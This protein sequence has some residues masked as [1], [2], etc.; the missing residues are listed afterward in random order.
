MRH[1]KLTPI[2]LIALLLGGCIIESD[3]PD[4]DTELDWLLPK[5]IKKN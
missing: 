1:V 2:L 5:H 3:T 4:L